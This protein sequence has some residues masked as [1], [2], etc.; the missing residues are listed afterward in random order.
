M[1]STREAYAYSRG[2]VRLRGVPI[3]VSREFK[4]TLLAALA[5][6]PLGVLL[7]NVGL[8]ALL[9]PIAVFSLGIV[10]AFQRRIK[11]DRIALIVAYLIGAEVLWRMAGVPIPWE[12]GKYG[13]AAIMIIALLNRRPFKVPQLPLLYFAA[14]IPACIFPFIELDLS[15]ARAHISSALSGPLSLAVSCWFF[16]NIRTTPTRLRR[17]MFAILI[18]LLSVACATLF[19]TVTTED[20][21]FNTESNFAT[22]GGFGPNQVSAMLGLGVFIAACCLV[23]F[24][25]DVKFKVL[26]GLG[27]VFFA[28]Q[29]V[30]TFS[31]GGIYN[32]IGA[33]LTLLFF[34]FRNLGEG[35]KR[36]VPVL[37]LVFVFFWF[38]FPALDNFTGGKLGERFDDTSTTNRVEIA[39]TDLGI[40]YEY[41]LTGAGVGL[42][43]EYR[44]QLYGS[45]AGSHT[46]FSRLISEHGLFGIIALTAIVLMAIV[47]IKRQQSNFGRALV[48]GL[49]VWCALFMFNAGMRLAA[50]SYLWGLTFLTIVS[51]GLGRKTLARLRRQP[52][53]KRTN[54]TGSESFQKGDAV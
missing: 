49:A 43:N 47:N 35:V 31:R 23:S 34:Q 14:L 37:A 41:P 24:K 32:A 42:G 52:K 29:S 10:W 18:P 7:Y 30:M 26:L 8:F 12:F 21:L 28:A 4:F 33:S 48:A 15:Q 44:R 27:A 5:H 3:P 1:N 46:E 13:S 39:G 53:G 54:H 17:L 51:P 22:S 25:V 50:P 9:H 16:A 6:L 19:Y 45:G 11:L 2:M 40:F 20:I 36:L 38:V